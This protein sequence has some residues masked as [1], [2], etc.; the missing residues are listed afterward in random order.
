M[1]L[2]A[3][4][5]GRGHDP[6]SN[7]RRVQVAVHISGLTSSTTSPRI[8]GELGHPEIRMNLPACVAGRGHDPDSNKRLL[9]VLAEPAGRRSDWPRR[10]RRAGGHSAQGPTAMAELVV[11]AGPVATADN[12]SWRCWRS[13]RVAGLIGHGGTGGPAG[14]APRGRRRPSNLS[15]KCGHHT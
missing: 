7:K 3:C 4:V 15:G 12:G 14:T 10:H 13:R 1:N 6:D 2:P 9:A 5:A 11:P 8:S